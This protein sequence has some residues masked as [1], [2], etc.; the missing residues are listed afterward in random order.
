MTPKNPTAAQKFIIGFIVIFAAIILMAVI[1]NVLGLNFYKNS[2]GTISKEPVPGI[3]IGGVGVDDSSIGWS[4]S[5]NT[6]ERD[7]AEDSHRLPTAVPT[8][9]SSSESTEQRIIKRGDLTITVK[10]IDETTE[11]IKNLAQ[12]QGGYVE[13]LNITGEPDEFRAAAMTIRVAKENFDSILGQIKAFAT[14]VYME[15]E[16]QDDTT[17]RILDIES[18]IKNLEQTEAQYQ[19]ILK[20]ATRVE[21]IL[22]ITEQLNNTR[23]Q[24][25]RLKADAQKLNDRVDL[26]AIT[27]EMDEEIDVSVFGIQ[28]RPL[29]ELKQAFRAGLEGL[30]VVVNTIFGLIAALPAIIVFTGAILLI[31]WAGAELFLRLNVIAYIKKI[32]ERLGK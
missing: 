23:L 17:D 2:S 7:T 31:M 20:S 15:Q 9:P 8:T 18:Q 21:D 22:K 11:K 24:I 1:F 32:I 19:Q 28:W 10:E 29:Y 5:S 4:P 12:E 3:E 26:A 6:A 13:D 16:R 27:I 14:K 25:E 30:I